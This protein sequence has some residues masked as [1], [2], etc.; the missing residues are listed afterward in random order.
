MTRDQAAD[1]TSQRR[2]QSKHKKPIGSD[3]QLVPLAK[4][5]SYMSIFMM[6]NKPSILGQTDL[7]FAIRVH[8]EVCACGITSLYM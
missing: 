1:I 4:S 6:T 8:H 2:N 5:N 7:V 3:T